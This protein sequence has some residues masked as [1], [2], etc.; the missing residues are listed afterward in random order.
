MSAMEAASRILDDGKAIDT[1]FNE[2]IGTA[3]PDLKLLLSDAFELKKFLEAQ[4]A[5]RMPQA[6]VD[7][8]EGSQSAEDGGAVPAAGVAAATGRIQSPDDVRRR[9]D[10]LC[11]YYARHEPSSPIPLL[12]RRAQRLVGLSFTDLMQD[13]APGGISELRVV[14]GPDENG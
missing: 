14:A 5:R 3:G 12:L 1:L 10:D 9:L 4:V 13:L 2:R 7:G 8:A 11:E 6:G